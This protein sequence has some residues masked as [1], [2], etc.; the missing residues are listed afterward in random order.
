[1]RAMIF[2]TFCLLAQTAGAIS[3]EN[4][5][6]EACALAKALGKGTDIAIGQLLQIAHNWG[7]SD[8]AKLDAVFRPDLQKFNL[9]EGKVF[10]TADLGEFAQEYLIVAADIAKAQ[11]LYF[12]MIYQTFEGGYFFKNITFNS[13]FYEISEPPFLMVPHPVDCDD[14]AD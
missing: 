6:K 3:A 2:G 14:E 11:N 10:R 1:M 7:E 8:R 12:R 13:D 9:G 4:T 5:E